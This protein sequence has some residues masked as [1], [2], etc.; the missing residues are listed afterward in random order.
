HRQRRLT[1]RRRGGEA[2]HQREDS[3]ASSWLAR[4]I[5]ANTRSHG[6]PRPE[7]LVTDQPT[8]GRIGV[9]TASKS[10]VDGALTAITRCGKC[11]GPLGGT[12]GTDTI[13]QRSS[14]GVDL[15]SDLEVPIDLEVVPHIDPA[16]DGRSGSSKDHQGSVVHGVFDSR[17]AGRVTEARGVVV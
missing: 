3:Q 5:C 16:P 9:I 11:E 8:N 12:R 1:N 2:G 6:C 7:E 17:V 14:R 15:A 4:D 13:D 10:K